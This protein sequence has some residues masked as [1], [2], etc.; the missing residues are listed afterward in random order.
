[1]PRIALQS[2]TNEEVITYLQTHNVFDIPDMNVIAWRCVEKSFYDEGKGWLQ[3]HSFMLSPPCD[4]CC[5]RCPRCFRYWWAVVTLLEKV[6]R[7]EPLLWMFSLKH[8]DLRRMQDYLA[9]SLKQ[10]SRVATQLV[11]GGV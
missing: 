2:G 8:C 7:F 11:R 5:L 4:L 10:N 9:W 3:R 6:Q 1:M